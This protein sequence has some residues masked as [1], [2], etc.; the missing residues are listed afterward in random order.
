MNDHLSDAST[1]VSPVHGVVVI[2]VTRDHAEVWSLDEHRHAPIAVLVRH[3]EQDA[4]RHV[5][6][7]Q[8]RHGHASDEGFAGFFSDIAALVAD[9]G[10]IMIAGHGTGRANAMESFAEYLKYEHPSVFAKVSEF[11]Y[12]DI[13]HTTGRELAALAREWKRRQHAVGRRSATDHEE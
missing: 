3:D 7:G 8:F 9:A 11:R 2:S 13:P 5:R 6:T 12:V 10:E 1:N 4:H